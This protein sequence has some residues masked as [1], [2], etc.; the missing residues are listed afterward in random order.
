[1]STLLLIPDEILLTILHYLD[2]P[3]LYTL[4]KVS[5]HLRA[6]ATDPLLHHHRLQSAKQTLSHLLPNRPTN[7][8]A[9]PLF[10]T[11]RQH[12]Q[13]QLSQKLARISLKRKLSLRP[14]RKA[15]VERGVIPDP[16]GGVIAPALVGRAHELEKERVK[17]VVRGLLVGRGGI[18]EEVAERKGWEWVRPDEGERRP[19]VRELARRYEGCKRRKKETRWG[20]GRC[21]RWDPPRAKVLVLKRFYEMLEKGA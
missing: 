4:T 18:I 12:T 3:D 16:A 8:P 14:E 15:L 2:I 6:T 17:D 13:R 20:S 21:V 10:L 9:A 1:M 11:P 19:R 5:R 7:P